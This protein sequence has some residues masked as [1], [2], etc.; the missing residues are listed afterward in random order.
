MF[1]FSLAHWN[2]SVKG[3]KIEAFSCKKCTGLDDS[4]VIALVQ[5]CHDLEYLELSSKNISSSSVHAISHFCR[6]LFYLKIYGYD[7]NAA[8]V[9]SLLTKH[10]FIK[11]VFINGCSNTNAIYLCK[12]TET[13]SGILEPHSHSSK[14]WTYGQT[15]TSYCAI[16]IFLTVCPDLRCL[17]LP[18]INTAVR[19]EVI[20]I[21]FHKCSF[22][23]MVLLQS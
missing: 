11:Y 1:F 3:L 2:L 16:E 4:G 17:T 6:N 20:D 15:D 8:S 14:L 7:F 13:K 9:E 12:S 10:R 19:D 21:A 23:E 18:P 5:N 22:I